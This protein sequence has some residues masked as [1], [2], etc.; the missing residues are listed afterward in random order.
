MPIPAGDFLRLLEGFP[1]RRG[2]NLL[3][4]QTNATWGPLPVV[5][6]GFPGCTGMEGKT[7][8]SLAESAESAEA[9]TPYLVVQCGLLQRPLRP[10]RTSTQFSALSALSVRDAVAVGSRGESRNQCPVDP[11]PPAGLSPVY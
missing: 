11:K 7:T 9:G 3:Q 6:L 5:L 1:S 10:A 4:M 8:N 2:M